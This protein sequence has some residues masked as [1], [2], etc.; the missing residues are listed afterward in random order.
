L[1]II[2]R[3]GLVAGFVARYNAEH[4]HSGLNGYSSNSVHDGSWTVVATRRQA[5]LDT[6]HLAHPGRYRRPPQAPIPPGTVWINKPHL[7]AA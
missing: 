5:L 2:G 7:D 3:P 4:R 6:H 1:K